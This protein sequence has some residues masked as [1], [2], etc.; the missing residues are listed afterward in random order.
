M[1]RTTTMKVNIAVHGKLI[2]YDYVKI[3]N[4]YIEAFIVGLRVYSVT[5]LVDFS[6]IQFEDIGMTYTHRSL[7]SI[8]NIEDILK[9]VGTD[10]VKAYLD[11]E[12]YITEFLERYLNPIKLNLFNI[13]INSNYELEI[14]N[15]W[16]EMRRH[17]EQIT[18]IRA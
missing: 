16:L 1:F 4:M 9:T 6:K 2:D 18:H 8:S 3:R 12:S 10:T 15:K 7:S 14:T 13:T 11:I 5:T 17:A